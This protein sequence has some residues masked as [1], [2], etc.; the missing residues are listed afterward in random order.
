MR[1]S[2]Q[3]FV[4]EQHLTSSCNGWCRTPSLPIAANRW[5]PQADLKAAPVGAVVLLR[6]RLGRRARV[7]ARP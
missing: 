7:K 2:P 3:D 5:G 1:Q 6:E 4:R